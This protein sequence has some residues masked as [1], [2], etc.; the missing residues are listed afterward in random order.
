MK[1][2]HSYNVTECLHSLDTSVRREKDKKKE[3]TNWMLNVECCMLYL[4]AVVD[5]DAV[6]ARFWILHM[7]K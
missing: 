1:W 6:H 2:S 4:H 3:R 5:V 7:D